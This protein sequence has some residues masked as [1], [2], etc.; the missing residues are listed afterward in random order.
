M[1]FQVSKHLS[2]FYEV[3]G[4]GVPLVLL[5]GFTGTHQTWMPFEVWGDHYQL[6][7]VDIVGHG[8]SQVQNEETSI[9]PFTMEAMAHVLSELLTHLNIQRAVVLGYSMGGRLALYFAVHYPERVFAL[10]LESASPGLSDAN[11][12]AARREKDERL[13]DQ[14]QSQGLL[15]FVDH[16]E[17]IPLF[18]SQKQLPTALR[19]K[20]RGERLSQTTE[21]LSGS[22]R[23]MGTG[24][25]PSLWGD[26]G[27][28]NAP[29]Y[30]IVGEWDEKFVS[31][32]HRMEEKFPNCRL[33]VVPK[34]GHA[35][36]VEQFD[37]F[38]RIVKNTIYPLLPKWDKQ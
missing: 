26:L 4:E 23:G 6:I 24:H 19:E 28:F 17:N 27:H 18:A 13:A 9:Y 32:A 36:H 25:Q 31:I 8:E 10:I 29:V 1:K 15:S 2:L 20:T 38:V 5:H 12:Q 22:L 3:K 7:L 35:V 16:W 37:F 21:G 14:I 33:W 11:E 30:L 34:A